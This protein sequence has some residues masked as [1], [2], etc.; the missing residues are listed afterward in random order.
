MKYIL[1]EEPEKLTEKYW[2]KL[3]DTDNKGEKLPT[4]YF[5]AVNEQEVITSL[6]P[7]IKGTQTGTFKQGLNKF[8][9]KKIRDK[10]Q[11]GYKA[12]KITKFPFKIERVAANEKLPEKPKDMSDDSLKKS[13]YLTLTD[14]TLRSQALSDVVSYKVI[15]D[16]KELN[17]ASYNSILIHHKNKH[18]NDNSPENLIIFTAKSESADKAV[19]RTLCNIGHQLAHATNNFTQNTSNE[20]KLPVYGHVKST[21]ENEEEQEH[22]KQIGTITVTMDGFN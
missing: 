17:P 11:A 18:E 5:Y 19:D 14:R 9:L 22:W 21:T 2:V 4:Y 10:Y 1:P 16:G 6:T 3:V 15:V 8:A 20:L 7:Q 12:N 13:P